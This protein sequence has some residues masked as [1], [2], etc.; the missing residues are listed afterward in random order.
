MKKFSTVALSFAVATTFLALA[1]GAAPNAQAATGCA[2]LPNT[3]DQHLVVR[4][5][6]LWVFSGD[7]LLQP[8]VWPRVWGMNRD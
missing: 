6:T 8:R 7:F 4:G 2:F 5:D 1:V 3:P